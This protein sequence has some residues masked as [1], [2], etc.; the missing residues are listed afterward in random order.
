MGYDSLLE[1]KGNAMVRIDFKKDELEMI[2]LALKEAREK[3]ADDVETA[4][5]YDNLIDYIET[6]AELDEPEAL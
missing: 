3:V 5:L 2:V 6:E 1:L 4:C